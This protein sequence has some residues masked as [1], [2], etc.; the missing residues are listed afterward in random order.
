MNALASIGARY[1]YLESLDS[2]RTPF[3]SP[4]DE[5]REL[6]RL[7]I[8]SEVLMS[9]VLGREIV[10]PQSYAFD[11][12]G[13][14]QVAATFLAARDEAGV[15]VSPFRL[16]LFGAVSFDDAVARMLGRVGL[17]DRPF[18]SSAFPELGGERVGDTSAEW[19]LDQDWLGDER[20]AALLAVRR[21][22]TRAEPPESR[23]RT[24]APG[25]SALLAE[26]ALSADSSDNEVLNQLVR[27]VRA[28]GTDHPGLDVRSSLRAAAPWPADPDGRTALEL[29][30]GQDRLDETIEF[31]DTL[32]NAV[33]AGSFGLATASFSTAL[34]NDSL[35]ARQTAQQVAIGHYRHQLA[36]PAVPGPRFEVRVAR[37]GA[38]TTKAAVRRHIR[39]LYASAD[40]AL[41][42][43]FEQMGRPRSRFNQGLKAL[44]TAEQ[45]GNAK[46]ARKALNDHVKHVESLLRDLRAPTFGLRASEAAIAVAVEGGTIA[47]TTLWSLPTS[48][49]LVLAG[50][51]AVAGGAAGT[52]LEAP[53]WFKGKRRAAALLDV[54][55]P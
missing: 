8:F 54:V 18:V 34:D 17:P 21:E 7:Q 31:V 9:L 3:A 10:V 33:V 1:Q 39:E 19:L 24:S 12:W 50:A 40:N 20:H 5:T 6:A 51:G 37:P 36:A 2:V 30:G 14:Q 46:E 47:A 29:V 43:L 23:P 41:P 35:A 55:D 11:S 16:H 38:V 45:D 22:F 25:L 13:F 42:Q 44:R 28:L 15:Q 49:Q 27:S 4:D 53:G 48:L 52:M 26:F 32:Y